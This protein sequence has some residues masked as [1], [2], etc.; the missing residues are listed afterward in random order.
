MNYLRFLDRLRRKPAPAP[1]TLPQVTSSEWSDAGLGDAGEMAIRRPINIKRS[2]LQQVFHMN[3][4]DTMNVR[5]THDDGC[6]NVAR[7]D[8]PSFPI[9]RQ[10]AVDSIT[11]FE[12]IDEFG[13]DVGI[14]FVLGGA[15][16]A[17]PAIEGEQAEIRG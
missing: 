10:I 9:E 6:G 1:T 16:K 14:G 12:V 7:E 5:I 11:K 4:G 13:V 15:K 2:M 3:T 17:T 8:T